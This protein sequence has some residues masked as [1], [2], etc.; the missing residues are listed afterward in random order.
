MPLDS[1]YNEISNLLLTYKSKLN[2]LI[3]TIVFKVS[4]LKEYYEPFL[5]DNIQPIIDKIFSVY[6]QL[7]E[8]VIT[9]ASD[10]IENLTNFAPLVKE[11]LKTDE[12][13][14]ILSNVEDKLNSL[15]KNIEETIRNTFY[16]ILE[17][18]LNKVKD[19][20]INL[21]KESMYNK[22]M[23]VLKEI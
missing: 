14:Q 16:K 23:E 9:I 3:G 20:F 8:K 4:K 11:K 5:K 10:V 18:S 6:N 22:I 19:L 15:L 17:N 7:T 2:E 1:I 12:L 13:H 21:G